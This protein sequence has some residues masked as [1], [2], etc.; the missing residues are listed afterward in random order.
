[1]QW[2]DKQHAVTTQDVARQTPEK[3]GFGE[4]VGMPLS[5]DIAALGFCFVLHDQMLADRKCKD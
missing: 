5:G 4:L 3:L 2:L 1:M